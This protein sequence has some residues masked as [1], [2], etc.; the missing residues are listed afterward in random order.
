M[1]IHTWW[2]PNHLLL[3][4][5][6]SCRP[7][8]SHRLSVLLQLSAG[9]A[10]NR[11][12]FSLYSSHRGL[13]PVW[14]SSTLNSS[15]SSPPRRLLWLLIWNSK[16]QPSF[17][18]VFPVV[19]RPP[20]LWQDYTVAASLQTWAENSIQPKTFH[21]HIS[22]HLPRVLSSDLA[23]SASET[24]HA[25]LLFFLFFPAPS[26]YMNSHYEWI[27]MCRLSF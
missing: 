5:L 20:H 9:W 14:F 15:I 6:F 21:I 24:I 16:P 12:F 7:N 25:W 18:C 3:L 10:P 22:P 26:L 8:S 1:W 11:P 2:A 17:P 13:Q 19:R 27:S 23:A 4:L